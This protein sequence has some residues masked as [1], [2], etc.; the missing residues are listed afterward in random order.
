MEKVFDDQ[1]NDDDFLL[2]LQLHNQLN[3]EEKENEDEN[4]KNINQVT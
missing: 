4:F 1:S 2:A 3:Q